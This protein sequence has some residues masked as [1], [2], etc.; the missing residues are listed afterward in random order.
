M[1]CQYR[2]FNV[3]LENHVAEVIINRPDKANSLHVKAWE[4]MKQV[5]DDL[6]VN[7]KA[8]VIILRGEGKH[9]CAG[10]DLQA[11]MGGAIQV[12]TDCD[13]KKR[14]HIRK[15]IVKIQNIITS[16]EDC[17]KPVIAA[18]HKAC[19]GGGI[20]IVT[21]CD[22]RYCTDDAFFSIKETDLGLVAD[23]GV[24]Q[25]LPN[26]INP[27]FVAE[28]AFTGREFLGQEAE[29]LGLV[30]KSFNDQDSMLEE[31]RELASTI[32]SKSPLVMKGVKEMLLYKRDH[33][34]KESMDFMALYNSGML[35]S[36]D[37][38]ESFEAYTVKR[39]PK[40]ED[41]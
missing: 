15:F 11:L 25:R 13:A 14:D 10:M 30:T 18:I 41:L 38:Y 27:G 37:L 21:A 9:F 3:E 5:F 22:M 31:V 7:P 35:L 17:K 2:Y 8:R 29:K 19:V 16:I 36:K 28:L 33:S 26:I 12:D 39:K 32:A 23:I 34:V 1:E 4:E 20:N 6:S 40:Y 24:L